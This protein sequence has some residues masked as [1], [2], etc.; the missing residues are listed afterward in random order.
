MKGLWSWRFLA[1]TLHVAAG[2]SACSEVRREQASEPFQA[3]LA[4]DVLLSD[5]DTPDAHQLCV[6][7]ADYGAATLERVRCHMQGLSLARSM[8]TLEP[9]RQ[10]DQLRADCEGA[11]REGDAEEDAEAAQSVQCQAPPS[12]SVSVAQYSQCLTDV[13]SNAARID[14]ELPQCAALQREALASWDGAEPTRR[15]QELP[16]SCEQQTLECSGAPPQGRAFVQ[17]YCAALQ[18]CCDAEALGNRC[19]LTLMSYRARALDLEASADCLVE[20]EARSTR[21][22]FCGQLAQAFGDPAA[23]IEQ[24]PAA[25]PSDATYCPGLSCVRLVWPTS[26]A[27]LCSGVVH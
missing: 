4:G 25:C 23:T 20:L 19:E 7:A 24:T 6:E 18:P 8:L 21:P 5:L 26:L 9:A 12:C 11:C 17:R 3:S 1:A 22:D 2:S 16:A 15:L 27:A 13:I 10:T 14:A